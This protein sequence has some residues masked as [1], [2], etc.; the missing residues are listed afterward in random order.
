M[1][2]RFPKTI[3]FGSDL[4]IGSD[5]SARVRIPCS[6]NRV[7]NAHL[8]HELGEVLLLHLPIGVLG[9]KG[10][11]VF[12]NLERKLTNC[13]LLFSEQCIKRYSTVGSFK[14]GLPI[15]LHCNTCDLS[16]SYLMGQSN[17]IFDLFFHN[18]S[19]PG[20]LSSGLKG[21]PRARKSW[22]NFLL[23]SVSWWRDYTK[24]VT[25]NTNFSNWKRGKFIRKKYWRTF[26]FC[27]FAQL[28]IQFIG[29]ILPIYSILH[30][31]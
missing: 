12:P 13:F 18:S 30:S 31:Q 15:C 22:R 8:L 1:V 20:P 17:E 3:R 25:F 26:L 14:K 29:N 7:P 28:Q 2:K 21:W 11:E 23:T 10:I 6:F 19:L 9:N 27:K 24:L 4:R 16:R 5:W